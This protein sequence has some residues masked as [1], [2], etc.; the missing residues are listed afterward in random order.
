MRGI[1]L[2]LLACLIVLPVL[3]QDPTPEPQP[4][5]TPVIETTEEAPTPEATEPEDNTLD[6]LLA[7][8]D[9]LE[10]L[11]T[12]TYGASRPP[13]WSGSRD[14]NDPQLA[15]LI[16]LDLEILAGALLGAEA[17][18]PGW[19]GVV[20]STPNA[21]A[22]DIRH[23]LELLADRMITNRPAEWIGGEPLMRCDRVTQA[24][25]QFLEKSGVFTLMADRTAP[26]FCA[27]AA[28]EAALFV[29]AT[30]LSPSPTNRVIVDPSVPQ[31]TQQDAVG[32]I[33]LAATIR[34]GIMP[35]GTQLEPVARDGSSTL[36]MVRGD[37]FEVFVDYRFTNINQEAF[38]ALPSVGSVRVAPF[39][40][41]DWCG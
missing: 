8:R 9:D 25:V 3:A 23:D 27:Q 15:I 1:A 14:V 20:P 7:A 10:R 13:G 11:A 26:D 37:G 28:L 5:G 16:R 32:F 40:T 6:L 19:F 2:I 36:M 38:E 24:L 31:I 12:A 35:I 41:A 33:D 39:C 18:L 30:Y 22:R 29:E 21:I 34:A 17:P 4:V